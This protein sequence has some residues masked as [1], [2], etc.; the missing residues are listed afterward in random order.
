MVESKKS[1]KPL[2]MLDTL[3]MKKTI[4]KMEGDETC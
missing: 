3:L 2:S 4:E 1:E